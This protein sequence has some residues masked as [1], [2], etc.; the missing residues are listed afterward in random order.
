[1]KFRIRIAG[2]LSEKESKEYLQ[3]AQWIRRFAELLSRTGTL[4]GY[5]PAFQLGNIM[6]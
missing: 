4:V 6:V 1:M 5:C 3:K 2:K